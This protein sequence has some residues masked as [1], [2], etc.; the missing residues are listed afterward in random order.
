MSLFCVEWFC[1]KNNACT[2]TLIYITCVKTFQENLYIHYISRVTVLSLF[3]NMVVG[4]ISFQFM[5]TQSIYI[6]QT[7]IT[8]RAYSRH[9][10]HGGIFWGHI[11]WKKG[12]LFTC[13]PKQ[14]SFLTISNENIS[15]KSQGNRLGAIVAPN[16]G[17]E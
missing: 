8:Y 10:G 12:F 13:T 17:L 2:I 3:K 1:V 9:W 11:F 16:K 14:L 5:D 7:N 4:I 15:L 6:N